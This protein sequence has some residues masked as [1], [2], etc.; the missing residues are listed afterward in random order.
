MSRICRLI[1]RRSA[2]VYLE[3][4]YCLFV[5][6]KMAGHYQV[7]PVIHNLQ[8]ERCSANDR[9]E[10]DWKGDLSGLNRMVSGGIFKKYLSGNILPRCS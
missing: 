2:E 9:G 3:A 4:T 6:Q 1:F 7:I 8:W 10:V 5:R